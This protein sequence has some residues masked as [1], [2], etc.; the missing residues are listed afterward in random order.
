VDILTLNHI[1]STKE[2]REKNI[3][4]IALQLAI[5]DKDYHAFRNQ[6]LKSANETKS[7]IH[8]LSITKEYPEEIEW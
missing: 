5:Q 3:G 7:D 1:N 2:Q 8:D 4:M 6:V